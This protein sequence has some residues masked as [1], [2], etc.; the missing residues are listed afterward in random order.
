M[1]S[2]GGRSVMSS[3]KNQT[4]PAL[5]GKSPVM[6]LKSVVFPAPLAPST[7][8]RSPA[9]TENDTSSIALSAPNVRVTRSSTRASPEASGFA[10]EE[11]DITVAIS[12]TSL[13]PATA[14]YRSRAARHVAR[15]QAHLVELVLAQAERLRDVL[16]HFH[17]PVVVFAVRLL[18]DLG[19]VGIPD[20]V[21]VLVDP[22]VARRALEDELLQRVA[23][24]L[25]AAGEIAFDRVEPFECRFGAEVVEE[26]EQRRA[27]E[28]VLELGLVVADEL[29]P[30][31]RLHR[32]RHGP[33]G[34]RAQQ[35]FAPLALEVQHRLIDRDGA[36]DHRLVAAGLLVLRQEV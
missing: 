34:W 29:L 3:P 26:G 24:G 22:D 31:R 9:A 7:A 30:F 28:A 23:I 6:A 11:S 15:A 33:G 25:L 4:C 13:G 5:G 1:R 20:A 19:D 12:S 14:P 36:A 18:R 21:A 17:D 35:G 27:R 2:C 32:I 16:S 10:P 8:R